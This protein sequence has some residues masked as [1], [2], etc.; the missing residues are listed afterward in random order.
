MQCNWTVEKHTCIPPWKLEGPPVTQISIVH[1]Q[2]QKFTNTKYS[3]KSM[4]SRLVQSIPKCMGLPW[5]VV[6]TRYCSTDRLAKNDGSFFASEYFAGETREFFIWWQWW[7][8]TGCYR[9]PG[10]KN[11]YHETSIL[12][13]MRPLK[14]KYYNNGYVDA[15]LCLCVQEARVLLFCGRSWETRN[16]C[17]Q[18]TCFLPEP[19]WRTRDKLIAGSKW[20]WP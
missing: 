6:V 19:T 5:L 18:A 10:W 14:L 7:Q 15:C 9:H 8:W 12:T 2:I 11:S 17:I 13:S 20:H 3:W 1:E 4:P 16:H